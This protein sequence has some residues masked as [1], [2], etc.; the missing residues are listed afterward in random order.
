[1]RI[2][3]K[4][5]VKKWTGLYCIQNYFVIKKKKKGGVEE[6]LC[7]GSISSVYCIVIAMAVNC[8]I[9]WSSE[10]SEPNVCGF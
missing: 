5:L 3:G 9:K 4:F 10:T 2:F 1:M 6:V 7:E 8:K